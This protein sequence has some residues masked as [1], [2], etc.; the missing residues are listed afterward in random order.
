MPQNRKTGITPGKRSHPQ[1]LRMFASLSVLFPLL[2]L[3]GCVT[4]HVEPTHGN[5]IDERV[6]VERVQNELKLNSDF[7]FSHVQVRADQHAVY[8]SGTV[9]SPEAKQRAQQITQSL[10][11]V[12]TLRN[13]IRVVE[14]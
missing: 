3:T 14:E 6:T 8:L 5:I 4:H 9:N 10:P 12:K 2:L 7:D 11:R 1:S 13:E